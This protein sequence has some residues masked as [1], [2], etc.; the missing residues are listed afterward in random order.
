MY[1]MRFVLWNLY[2]FDI[3]LVMY[4]LEILGNMFLDE[5]I[6][7]EIEWNNL[8]LI[9][10]LDVL[11]DRMIYENEMKNELR[12]FV[13]LNLEEYYLKFIEKLKNENKELI[14]KYEMEKREL[15]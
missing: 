3:S 14:V 9:K 2:F 5:K 13:R 4:L 8:G 6:G 10:V 15:R 7:V 12:G 11:E 1:E